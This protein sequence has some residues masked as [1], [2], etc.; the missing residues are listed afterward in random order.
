MVRPPR[1][2]KLTQ[3]CGELRLGL[4][5]GNV[6]L[7]TLPP[8]EGVNDEQRLVRSPLVALLPDAQIVEPLQD[9][10]SAHG[11]PHH[12]KLTDDGT[13]HHEAAFL[14]NI[15]A[16]G[17][18]SEILQGRRIATMRTFGEGHLVEEFHGH[19]SGRVYEFSDGSRWRQEDNTDEPVYR[20]R[21]KAKLLRDEAIGKTYP[22]VEGTSAAVWVLQDSSMRGI[23]VGA[24]D[25]VGRAVRELDPR[26]AAAA[27]RR[28]A[29]IG[30][31]VRTICSKSNRSDPFSRPVLPAAIH[32][33]DYEETVTD[34]EAVARR[35]LDACGLEWDPA[36]LEFHRTRRHVRTASLAQV[37]QPMYT[38]SLARWRN[39]ER[40][41]AE[42]FEALPDERMKSAEQP[43]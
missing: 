17:E 41:L 8:P 28:A 16:E 14:L 26:R 40:A 20:D 23:S 35:L 29:G 15:W 25:R 2:A 38:T 31:R 7:P 42:L 21:P 34:L 37:R 27:D 13:A 6:G 36:C 10:F 3:E 4:T 11:R 43:L 19:A 39:Y 5:E 24:S 1:W 9:D 33:V 22:D 30:K 12:N 32:E 18:E